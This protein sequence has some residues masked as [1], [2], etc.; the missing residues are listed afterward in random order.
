MLLLDILRALQGNNS[1][2]EESSAKAVESAKYAPS[3]NKQDSNEDESSVAVI[4]KSLEEMEH[5]HNK[6]NK[7]LLSANQVVKN[8]EVKKLLEFPEKLQSIRDAIKT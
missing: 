5:L 7:D 8:P 1:H 2:K 3:S 4:M 6:I